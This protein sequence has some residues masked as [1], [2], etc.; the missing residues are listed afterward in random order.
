MGANGISACLLVHCADVPLEV[1]CPT[2]GL[3]AVRARVVLHPL[4]HCA[5]VAVEAALLT[6]GLLALRAHMV[7]LPLVHRADV[8]GEVLFRQKASSCGS[9]GTHGLSF[10]RTPC[11]RA[12]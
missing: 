5:D 3:L 11:K 1:A 10:P 9:A 2:E 4:V 12:H 6:E 7:L 8:V